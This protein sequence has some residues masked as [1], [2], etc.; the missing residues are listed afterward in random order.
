M[1]ITN[2]LLQREALHGVQRNLRDLYDAHRQVTTGQRI[3]KP[4]DDPI[5]AGAAM[6]ADAQ[7]RAIER[8][9]RAIGGAEAR[10]AAEEEVL[11]RLTDLLTRARELALA[12]AG[13]PANAAT[14][15]TARV[16]IDSILDT[17]VQLANTRYQGSYLFGGD[18][19]DLPPLTET[20]DLN[21]AYPA[22]PLGRHSVEISSGHV[23][24]VQHDAATVFLES[25]VVDALKALSAALAAN[26]GDAVRDTLPSIEAA[27]D[28]TQSLLG[29]VGGRMNTLEVARANLSAWDVHLRT[30]RSDLIDAELD[31]AV[32]R[33]L[34]RQTAY[35]A[36]LAA[37]SRILQTSLMD[38]L[39]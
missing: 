32:T 19:A 23:L 16:E 27:F 35:Q 2:R 8:Y 38:Y 21:P 20:G 36:A 37:N 4:S 30:F 9:A 11:D 12:N 17:V 24:P 7:I 28:R 39:R 10:L 13:E 29:E 1:R 18:F 26:D 3:Q 6:R 5:A 22:G 15:E 14:R 25:G 34:N 33:L 31:E